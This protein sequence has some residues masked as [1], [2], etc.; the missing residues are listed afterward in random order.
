M[1]HLTR[2]NGLVLFFFHNDLHGSVNKEQWKQMTCSSLRV[3]ISDQLSRI[4]FI[5]LIYLLTHYKKLDLKR[6]HCLNVFSCDNLFLL[7]G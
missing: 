7:V 6:K 2:D 5:Y 1:I 4:F 3:M